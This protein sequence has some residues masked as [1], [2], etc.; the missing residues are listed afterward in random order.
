MTMVTRMPRSMPISSARRR[1]HPAQRKF[2]PIRRLRERLREAKETLDAIRNGHVDAL[3]VQGEAGDQIFTLVGADH[4]YRQ[5]VETM[6]EGALLV[7][8][9]GTIVYG[10]ARFAA[11]AE[12]PLE[13]MS[14]ARL[15]DLV[16]SAA[17]GLLDAVLQGRGGES[18]KAEVELTTSSGGRTPVYLSATAGWGDD[19]GLTCVIVTDLSE[20]KRSQ[21]MVVAERLAAR[22]VDQAA[23]GIV[24]CEPGGRV[25]RASRTAHRVAGDN[26]LLRRFE[27]AFPF[28]D[29]EDHIAEKIVHAALRGQT[30]S[31]HEVSLSLE[32]REPVELLLSAGPILGD[33]GSPLGCVISFV[34]ITERRRAARERLQILEGAEEARNEAVRANRAKDEFLAML[35]HELRNPLSPVLTALG[36]MRTKGGAETL[37]EREVIER[38]V[39]LMARLVDDLLDVAR[40][41]QGKITL[42]RQPVDFGVVVRDAIDVA[43]PLIKEHRHRL[44]VE[45]EDGLWVD[46][47]AARLCQVVANLRTNAGKSTPAGGRI[48]ARARNV[49]GDIVLTVR[50]NGTGIPPEIVATLF[51]RFVQGH[52]TL[53]RSEGG[54]GLGLAI[55]RSLVALHGGTAVVRSDGVGQGSEFEIRLPALDPTTEHPRPVLERTPAARA[56]SRRVLVVDDNV[57]NADLL[58]EALTACGYE[59]RVAYNGPT[60]L[61]VAADFRPEIAFLDIGLPGMDGFELARRLRAAHDGPVQL[62]AITGYGQDTDRQR[63]SEAGF[64]RHLVKPIQLQTLTALIE[65]MPAA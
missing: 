4:R 15:H 3:V 45:L 36:L 16:P 22:I 7:D 61:D 20:Q 60:A 44:D 40:I 56:G 62:V 25:I 35:G 37:R 58:G 46:G 52:R 54:L 5:L 24:V 32:D 65:A 38:Q 17:H 63:S 26:P 19:D 31:G 13:R 43:A 1:D 30:I 28:T 64:D 18:S 2:D 49:D 42:D 12:L 6:N 50:D 9:A 53:D 39:H 8:S 47:D 41:A 21:E 11:L 10:N 55:V 51:E 57:D 29:G 14:G 23:E 33:D 48:R 59:T 27:D 34:D